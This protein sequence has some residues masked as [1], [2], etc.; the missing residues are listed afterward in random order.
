MFLVPKSLKQKYSVL[1]PDYCLLNRKSFMLGI[2]VVLHLQ[3]KVSSKSIN[4]NG[5]RKLLLKPNAVPTINKALDAAKSDKPSETKKRQ[6]GILSRR[7]EVDHLIFQAKISVEATNATEI[8]EATSGTETCEQE[9]TCNVARPSNAIH[10]QTL[11]VEYSGRSQGTQTKESTKTKVTKGTQT[12]ITSDLLSNYLSK[13]KMVSTGSQTDP[14]N[15]VM[16]KDENTNSDESGKASEG[17]SITQAHW[18]LAEVLRIQTYSNQKMN[19]T[20]KK[21]LM[22]KVVLKTVV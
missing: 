12:Y 5:K 9:V 10:V 4:F 20:L 7:K 1:N 21:V 19:Q 15:M 3:I 11:P 18:K 16:D 8:E 17:V 2:E 14:V 13:H 22:K 6:T